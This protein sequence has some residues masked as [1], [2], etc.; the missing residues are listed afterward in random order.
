[1]EREVSVVWSLQPLLLRELKI[2]QVCIALPCLLPHNIS[3]FGNRQLYSLSVRLCS[4]TCE[5]VSTPS[6]DVHLSESSDLSLSLTQ[7]EL[8]EDPPDGVAPEMRAT[9]GGR[10]D[11][12][13]HSPDGCKDTPQLDCES[14][15]PVVTLE[16]YFI[17][18]F[19]TLLSV[20]VKVHQTN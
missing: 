12:S 15:A 4:G 6:S 3:L 8:E 16:R 11:H 1:M 19:S 7:S 2:H 13:R 9:S 14:S 5:S 20:I 18:R 10:D 17:Y